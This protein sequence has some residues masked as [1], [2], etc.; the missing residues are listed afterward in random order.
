VRSTNTGISALVDPLGRIT[1][2]TGQWTRET[3]VG[4]VPLMEHGR[5][6]A[7]MKAGDVVGW[8]ACAAV[9]LGLVRARRARPQRTPTS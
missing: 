4:E 7:Y 8:L 9:A 3:L 5:S 2:R 1:S 6:T